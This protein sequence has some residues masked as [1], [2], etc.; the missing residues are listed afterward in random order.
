MYV[1]TFMSTVNTLTRQRMYEYVY[2][3]LAMFGFVHREAGLE[4]EA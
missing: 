2:V 3:V 1:Y 4:E